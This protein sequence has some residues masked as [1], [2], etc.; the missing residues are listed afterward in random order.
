MLPLS[1]LSLFDRCNWGV[2]LHLFCLLKYRQCV[3][4]KLKLPVIMA[5]NMTDRS[6]RAGQS[7]VRA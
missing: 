4:Q 7:F 3:L 2:M 1:E 5:V 6:C